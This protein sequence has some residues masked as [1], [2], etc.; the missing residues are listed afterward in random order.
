[1]TAKEIAEKYVYGR[2]DALTDRQEVIDMGADIIAFAERY[3]QD[4]IQMARD[5]NVQRDCN[6]KEDLIRMTSNEPVIFIRQGFTDEIEI[7]LEENAP[8]RKLRATC[9]L[10][11]SEISRDSFIDAIRIMSGKIKERRL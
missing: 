11:V 4:K 5:I 1:M 9:N 8:E 10:R 2:H 3:A 7:I 6:F